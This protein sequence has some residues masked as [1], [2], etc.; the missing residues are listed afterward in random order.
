M[1][2][3]IREAIL[4]R[5][6]VHSAS[7]PTPAAARYLLLCLLFLCAPVQAVDWLAPLKIFGK[8]T[9]IV[10]WQGPGMYVKIVEQDR[11]KKYE[12]PAKNAH[13]ATIGAKDIAAV[14]ASLT[15]GKGGGPANSGS[16][17]FTSGEIAQVAPK[18][19]EALA[20]AQ[21]RQD[22]IF[23]V[24]DAQ[25]K[26]GRGV[27]AARVFVEAGRLN[28]ILGDTLQAGGG[29]APQVI[30]HDEAPWRPGRRRETLDTAQSMGGGPGISFRP[31]ARSPRYDWAIIDVRS[32]VAA[33]RG[34]QIPLAT[35]PEVAPAGGADAGA[36]TNAQLLQERQQMR[37]EM[38]RMRKQ[39][40]S[41]QGASAAAPAVPQPAAAASTPE[42]AVPVST[43][44][45]PAVPPRSEPAA[46]PAAAS[47]AAVAPPPAGAQSLEQRLSTLKTLHAKQLITDEEYAAKRKVILDEL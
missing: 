18:L 21:S 12:R 30:D 38:A 31:G 15:T 41:Q 16:P 47:A 11:F 42:P 39:L 14:L 32:V 13:P 40:E 1:A 24:S 2:T 19:A 9:E 37:L 5:N 34:P 27:T 35:V 36:E 3:G 26:S 33:Y 20:K 28:L 22:V 7:R 29:S 4:S 8:E 10:V 45:A 25:G 46:A 43:S 17:L 23:A 44:A 6:P